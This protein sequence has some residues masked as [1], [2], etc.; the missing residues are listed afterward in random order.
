MYSSLSSACGTGYAGY[1]NGDVYVV[2]TI[3]S[4]SDAAKKTN[5]SSLNGAL[6]LISQ[7]KPKTYNF[8][9]DQ[10]LNLPQEKQYGFLAQDVEQVLPDIVKTVE[11]LGERPQSGTDEPAQA[12]PTGE[13]KTV[14]Y[15]ALIPILV[16]GMQEQ[17]EII[18]AQNKRIAE[19]EAKINR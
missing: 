2:G 6:S 15:Q 17:Q 19:L 4:T 3:T 12:V 13:I 16:Q 14:N 18:D 7:L 10:D 1:F 8:K 5:I 11:T 9:V